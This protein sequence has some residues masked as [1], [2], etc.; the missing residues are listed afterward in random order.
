MYNI[1]IGCCEFC[2]TV[3]RFYF[4]DNIILS[5]RK[6]DSHQRRRSHHISQYFLGALTKTLCR[7]RFWGVVF[8]NPD[9]DN[10]NTNFI[11]QSNVQKFKGQNFMRSSY[12]LYYNIHIVHMYKTRNNCYLLYIYSRNNL[13]YSSYLKKCCYLWRNWQR[14]EYLSWHR[15]LYS[16]WG[17]SSITRL[18]WERNWTIDLRRLKNASVELKTLTTKDDAI[19]YALGTGWCSNQC[20][21]SII[22]F[23][24]ENVEY[25]YPGG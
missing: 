16:A 14:T 6:Y 7:R 10:F 19:L 3:T 11:L 18:L 2:C 21:L 9:V 20:I 17:N 23:L 5:Y 25:K 22:A 4:A 1:V 13:A 15:K 8:W 24:V 12:I